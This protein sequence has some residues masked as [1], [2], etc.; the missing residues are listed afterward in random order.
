MTAIMGYMIIN[1][2]NYFVQRFLFPW[3]YPAYTP[4]WVRPKLNHTR[5]ICWYTSGFE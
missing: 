2:A 4:V 1:A 3:E 5:L